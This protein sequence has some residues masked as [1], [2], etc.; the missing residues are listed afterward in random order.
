[1][2]TKL[3]SF[4]KQANPGKQGI[5]IGAVRDGSRLGTNQ[6][7]RATIF[8]HD[9]SDIQDLILNQ[10]KAAY[11]KSYSFVLRGMKVNN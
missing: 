10:C 6:L 3:N 1:M 5:V 7:E 9:C 8:L 4:T 2:P 11:S